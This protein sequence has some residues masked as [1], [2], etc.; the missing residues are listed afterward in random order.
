MRRIGVLMPLALD[1]PQGQART[2]TFR[3]ALRELG[4]TEGRN[5]RFDYRWGGGDAEL[6]RRYAAE[7]VALGPDVILAGGGLVVA[8]LQKATRTV[9][10]VFTA[11]LDPVTLGFVESLA[12]PGGNTTGFL[13]LEYS[14][15]AK[16]LQLLKEIAPSVTRVAVLRDPSVISGNAQFAAIQSMAS[17]FAVELLPVDV[18]DPHKIEHSITAFARE[19][20]GGLIVTASIQA[21]IHRDLIIALAARHRLPAVYPTPFYVA[22]GGL[23]SY[24]SVFD[25]QYRR[26]ADYVNRILKGAKPADLPV[27]A[28]IKYEMVLNLKTARALDLEIPDIVFARIDRSVE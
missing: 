7:L 25:E 16:W 3:Q 11:T 20:N 14:F 10:I 26:A 6:N 5:V 28:P 8:A 9:P 12:R 21:T 18:N 19:P 13:N 22:A 27:Q 1:D 4:W 24:G 17:L 2:S 15:S 23:I